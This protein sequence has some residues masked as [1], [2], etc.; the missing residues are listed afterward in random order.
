MQLN[1]KS[2]RPRAVNVPL[3]KPHPTAGGNVMSAPLVLV[4]L[5]TSEGIT[6]RSYL[7]CYT[8][9][10]LKPMVQLVR[11]LGEL[12]TG[13]PVS[14]LDLNRKL[15]GRLRLLG[16]QGLAGMAVAGI[17][18]AAWD[19]V[20]VAAGLPLASFLGGA[21]KPVPAYHSCGM[22]NVEGSRADAEETAALGF[23]A[24]KFKVGHADVAQDVAA[25]RT[26]RDAG[27]KV[28]VD[29][30]QSL[31]IVSAIARGRVLD[32]EGLVWIEEPTTAEDYAGHARIASALHT[33]IQMG[34]NMWGPG[35]LAKALEARACDCIMLDV[36]KIG[37]VTGWLAAA[38]LAEGRGLRV[39]SHLFPEI[40]AQL[41]SVTRSAQFLEYQDWA[42]PILAEP[43][44]VT[45]GLAQTPARPGAGLAWN[46]EVVARHLV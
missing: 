12:V 20:A 27:L 24:I 37:G 23:D 39:S 42:A 21:P 11:S 2:I 32:Q 31:D 41:L 26:A 8:A 13:D 36:M 44:I 35:D 22:S 4:D 45:K 46:E 1:I 25:I 14:P 9:L 7:F 15:Q 19:A 43:I 34:E 30:N 16:Q 38:A 18:M 40:S 29:Y 3:R 6:G 17:D 10:V 28:M 5:E 33:P